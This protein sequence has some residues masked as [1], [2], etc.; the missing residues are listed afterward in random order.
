LRQIRQGTPWQQAAAEAFAGQG[1]CGNGAAMRIAPLGAYF[2]DSPRHAAEEAALSAR[3]THA[4]PE[5][6]AGA[7][8]VAVAASH[9]AAGRLAGARP[10][11]GPFLDAVLELTPHGRVHSILVQARRMLHISVSQAAYE[12]GNGEQVTAQDTVPFTL[13]VAAKHL[14][15]Y[16]AAIRACVEAGGDADTTSAIVGGIVAAYTATAGIPA[17]WLA[18][19]E[20][21]PAWVERLA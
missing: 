16:P 6:V 21:L 10:K 2:P 19:R 1:S 7:I 9:A 8:A 20:P 11:P 4:H 3:V 15:D 18:A 17:D 13:W 5:G 14:D 12:L